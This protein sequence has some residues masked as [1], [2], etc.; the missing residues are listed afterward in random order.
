MDEIGEL[1]PLETAYRPLV[2]AAAVIARH[3]LR[4]MA[5]KGDIC[6]SHQ[7][8]QKVLRRRKI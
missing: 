8:A 1:L 7:Y 2:S 5:A 6:L 4:L 3:C